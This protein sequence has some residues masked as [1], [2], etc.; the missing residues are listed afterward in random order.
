MPQ[1]LQQIIEGKINKMQKNGVSYQQTNVMTFTFPSKP[2]TG[3]PDKQWLAEVSYQHNV[4]YSTYF[5]N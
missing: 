5:G 4:A 3:L 2:E 1:D